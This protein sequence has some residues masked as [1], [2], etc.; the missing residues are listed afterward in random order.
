M[1]WN[2]AG[3]IRG[4]N[5]FDTETYEMEFIENPYN[6]FEKV[7]YEDTPVNYSSPFV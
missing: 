6:M 7:Y 4:F 3:D 5:I 1:Y 2:D